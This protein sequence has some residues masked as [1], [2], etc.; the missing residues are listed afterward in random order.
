MMD[1]ILSI[2]TF[3]P[4]VG[5]A[6]IMGLRMLS[7]ADDAP[8]IERNAKWIALWTTLATLALS[9]W[10]LMNFDRSI[11]GYQFVEDYVWF[12][13]AGYHMGVDGISI[14]FVLLTAFLLPICIIASW[15]PIKERVTEY[16]I[17]FLVLETLIIGV[18][19]SLDLFLFYIFFEGGLVPMFLIIGI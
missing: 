14:L 13:G 2:V 15:N 9:V 7:R 3:L 12:A 11:P 16:L 19:T 4:L 8:K 18:F 6:A 17:C 5:A 1:H 10:L